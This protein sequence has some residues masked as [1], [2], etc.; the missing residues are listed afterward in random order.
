MEKDEKPRYDWSK[1]PKFRNIERK[2]SLNYEERFI[3]VNALALLEDA[4]KTV[5]K[6]E[7]SGDV[8]RLMSRFA[9]ERWEKCYE[10]KNTD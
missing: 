3:I 1:N 6:W 10:S 5:G 2:L 4:C 7:L 8:H 9:S